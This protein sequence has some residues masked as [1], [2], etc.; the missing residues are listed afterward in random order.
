MYGSPTTKEIKKKHSPRPIG[1]VEMGSQAEMTHCKAAG[2][3]TRQGCDWRSG[4]S[5]I[6]VQINREEQL[7]SKTDRATQGS[8]RGK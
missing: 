6:H 8:N 5:H 2:W 3:R 7:G 4:R 1:G